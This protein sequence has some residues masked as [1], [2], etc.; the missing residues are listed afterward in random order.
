MRPT[1]SNYRQLPIGVIYPRDAEDVEA[2]LAACWA[3]GA[4]VLPRGAGTS[5]AGQCANVAVVFDYS[6]FMNGLILIDPAAKL[7]TVEPGIV[8][9][10]L[11]DAAELLPPDVCARSG[12]PLPLHPGRHDR[13]Q[14]LRRAR[15]AGRQGGGQCAIARHHALRRHAPDG[16]PHNA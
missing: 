10:R 1:A 11:R 5:L 12:H 9:D 14:Q 4:A 16:W 13:Q 6:R 8:L 2:A 3:V 15:A 7:A